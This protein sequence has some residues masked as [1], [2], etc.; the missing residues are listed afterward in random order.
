MEIQNPPV[1]PGEDRCEF[2]TPKSILSRCE[3]GIHSHLLN[4][5]DWMST[6]GCLGFE[7]GYPY[8]GGSPH[9]VSS[10][11]VGVVSNPHS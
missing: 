6:V 8:L 3:L 5:H 2:G 11:L 9:F 10:W 7:S 1:I 4:R